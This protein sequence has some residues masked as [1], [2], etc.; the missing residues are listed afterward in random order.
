MLYGWL[1]SYTENLGDDVQ[2]VAA[3]QFYP[4]VDVVIHRE[5]LSRVRVDD[6][7][8]V[9]LNGWFMYRPWNWPP[10]RNVLPLLVSI[11]LDPYAAWWMLRG[12]GLAYFK[13]HGPVGAR[14]LYTLRI[15]RKR[16]VP[17][18]FSSCLTL[19]LDYRFGFLKTVEEGNYIVLVDVPAVVSQLM[20]K[21]FGDSVLVLSNELSVL[22]TFDRFVLRGLGAVDRRI[23]S[24]VFEGMSLA[25]LYGSFFIVRG[26][27]RVDLVTR[28]RKV[29]M[30]LSLLANACCVITTRLHVALPSLAFQ[31]PTALLVHDYNDPRFSGNSHLLSTYTL[32]EL[33]ERLRA[34]RSLEEAARIGSINIELLQKI[35]LKLVDIMNKFM[36]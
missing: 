20:R 5:Y 28:L 22:T 31:V 21:K 34:V 16:G 19:T 2:S 8:K 32:G 15:L 17:A 25:K 35:K 12:N 7:V 10:P 14:D 24:R 11:H 3:L 1:V 13:R 18:Y 36:S 30:L 33:L 6:E 29:F 4:R 9:V 26:G 27:G 23:V